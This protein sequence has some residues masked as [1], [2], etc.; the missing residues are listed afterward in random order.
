M[1]EA[2]HLGAQKH[3]FTIQ[4]FKDTCSYSF[5]LWDHSGEEI[6]LALAG[7]QDQIL[8]ISHFITFST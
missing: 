6:P 4:T 1:M 7:Q 2:S 5:M 8:F 3:E